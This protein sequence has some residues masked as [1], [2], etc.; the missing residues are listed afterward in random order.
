MPASWEHCEKSGNLV[1][2]RKKSGKF[3][4]KLPMEIFPEK[5]ATCITCK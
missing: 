3:L 2:A 5:K 4:F 1:K